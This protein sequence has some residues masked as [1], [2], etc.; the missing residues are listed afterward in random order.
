[1][2][3][4]QS[5]EV[6]QTLGNHTF[7]SHYETHEFI[8]KIVT[9]LK[10]PDSIKLN[11]LPTAWREKFRCLSL[12]QN[13]FMCMDERLVI[14]KSDY[15]SFVTLRASRQRHNVCHSLKHVVAALTPR[16]RLASENVPQ[17]VKTRVGNINLS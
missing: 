15:Y 5:N 10:K 1:M 11:R 17:S 3:Q 4:R 6:L 9:L 16:S 2:I 8:Q 12:D 13:N 7:A 14:P